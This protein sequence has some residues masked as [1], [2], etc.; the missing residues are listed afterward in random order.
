MSCRPT[1]TQ[2]AQ[3][4]WCGTEGPTNNIGACPKCHSAAFF[5]AAECDIWDWAIRGC[6][7]ILVAAVVGTFVWTLFPVCDIREGRCLVRST[8]VG[9]AIG[10]VVGLAVSAWRKF[11]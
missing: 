1:P 11:L 5:A 2:T 8:L 6:L 10:A 4:L 3:C 7:I 9:V